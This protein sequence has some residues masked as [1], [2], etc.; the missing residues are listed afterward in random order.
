MQVHLLK[1]RRLDQ[2]FI[3]VH[4]TTHHG[5][6]LALLQ[7]VV[8]LDHVLCA[9][10][11]EDEGFLVFGSALLIIVARCIFYVTFV[12]FLS[13]IISSVYVGKYIGNRKGRK[14]CNVDF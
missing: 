3:E 6:D 8:L 10:E 14:G 9:V 5:N 11:V 4:K 2:E 12:I 13:T 7:Q 1:T